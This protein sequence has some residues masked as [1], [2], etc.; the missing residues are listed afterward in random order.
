MNHL[1]EYMKLIAH[2][3]MW[4]EKSLHIW[5]EFAHSAFQIHARN[6]HGHKSGQN[7]GSSVAKKKCPKVK[8]PPT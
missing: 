7:I 1:S 3:S 2:R 6:D 5:I 4:K 8:C